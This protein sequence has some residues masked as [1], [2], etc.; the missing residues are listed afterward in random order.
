MVRVKRGR[1]SGGEGKIYIFFFQGA[2]I[3]QYFYL[4]VRSQRAKCNSSV[5]RCAAAALR[6]KFCTLAEL[7]CSSVLSNVRLV[8]TLLTC[9]TNA[10]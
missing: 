2:S 8:L 10:F 3:C 9:L 6:A 1:V 4:A 7:E 5:A